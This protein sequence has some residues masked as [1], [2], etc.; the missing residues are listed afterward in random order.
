VL[1]RG[2]LVFSYRLVPLAEAPGSGHEL[3]GVPPPTA[4]SDAVLEGV[5][6]EW[7]DFNSAFAWVTCLLGAD[8]QA[9]AFDHRGGPKAAHRATLWTA[10]AGTLLG[11]YLLSFLPGSAGDPL[12]PLVGLLAVGLVADSALRLVAAHRGRYAP[13]FFR[14]LLPS[15]SLRPE[16]LAF[17]AHRDAERRALAAARGEATGA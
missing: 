8:V 7:D 15:D 5:L 6:R 11:L 16:R 4:Y 17:H 3:G 9:R 2:R 12:A 1:E 10:G 13:S 14:F